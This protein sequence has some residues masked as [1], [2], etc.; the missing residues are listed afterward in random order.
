[1][2]CKIR[3]NLQKESFAK[4]IFNTICNLVLHYMLIKIAFVQSS[5]KIKPSHILASG[6]S[7]AVLAVFLLSGASE[8]V[9]AA[10]NCPDCAQ[11]KQCV[12][13]KTYNECHTD[14]TACKSYVTL[15][16]CLNNDKKESICKAASDKKR[17]AMHNWCNKKFP[18]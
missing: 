3:N 6:A 16:N 17:V 15:H 4:T 1:M 14:Y 7:V 8:T 10:T 18:K 13:P 11:G 5:Q 12:Y 2:K 9:Q